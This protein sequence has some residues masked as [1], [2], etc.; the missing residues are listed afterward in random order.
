MQ[1]RTFASVNRDAVRCTVAVVRLWFA[2]DAAESES[3]EGSA[4][5]NRIRPS[6]GEEP[7]GTEHILLVDDQF[8]VRELGKLILGRHGYTV[9]E[10]TDGEDA[11]KRFESSPE[12]FDL[13]LTDLV[14]PNLGGDELARIL[15]KSRPALRVVFMSGYSADTVSEMIPPEELGRYL[16]KPFSP[17]ELLRVVRDAL[18][19][20]DQSGAAT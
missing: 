17:G 9:L 18:D 2:M 4:R 15:R 20:E 6:D 10:A 13:L 3:G 5:A 12:K 11:L 16:Q 8:A 14:M 7:N 1:P 19:S